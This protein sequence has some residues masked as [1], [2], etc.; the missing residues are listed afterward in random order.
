MKSKEK[1]YKA[2]EELIMAQGYES[3]TVQQIADRAG[4]TERTFFR[5][6][7]DKSD[8]FF[9]GSSTLTEKIVATIASSDLINPMEIAVSGYLAAAE[10]FFDP[11]KERVKLRNQIIRNNPDLYERELLKM[12]ALKQSMTNA[13]GEKFDAIQAELASRIA[14]EIFDLGFNRWLEQDERLLSELIQEIFDE[15]KRIS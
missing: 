12:V 11:S 3:T 5:Q 8:V 9:A 6:F 13:L 15:Y 7:K 2:A 14:T 10:E 1:L 4:V